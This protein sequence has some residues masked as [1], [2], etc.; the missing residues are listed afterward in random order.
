ME[1]IRLVISQVVDW[2]EMVAGRVGGGAAV[3][4]RERSVGHE[5]LLGVG[6]G[7]PP[8]DDGC[9]HRE[10]PPH[11]HQTHSEANGRRSE[12]MLVSLTAML[13]ES[14]H[15]QPGQHREE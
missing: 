9:G 8:A 4:A 1:D 6:A 14:D 2:I 13:E 7:G 11:A 3:G 15:Y 10:P 5:G 12:E